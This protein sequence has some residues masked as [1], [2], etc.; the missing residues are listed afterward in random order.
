M[1]NSQT[2]ITVLELLSRNKER[3]FSLHA[4]KEELSERISKDD[5][6]KLSDALSFIHTN[7][8]VQNKPG[9]QINNAGEA[10]LIELKIEAQKKKSTKARI[11]ISS[12]IVVV[13]LCSNII[14]L[15]YSYSANN[16]LKA[17]ETEIQQLKSVK[18]RPVLKASNPLVSMP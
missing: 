5:S 16:D 7:G 11:L 6:K 17:K 8:L 15:A 12:M 1:M 2:R 14:T 10:H 4:V 18:S 13:L 3:G 9:F